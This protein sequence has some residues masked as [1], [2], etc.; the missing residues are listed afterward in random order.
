V[1]LIERL[2][3]AIANLNPT[4]NSDTQKDALKQ[5]LKTQTPSLIE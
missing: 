3:A 4:L 1:F 2:R 5:L